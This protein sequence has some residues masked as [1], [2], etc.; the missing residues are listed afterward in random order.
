MLVVRSPG[1]QAKAIH[2]DIHI[3]KGTKATPANK[4]SFLMCVNGAETNLDYMDVSGG[5]KAH[6]PGIQHT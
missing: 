1:L 4:I 2:S 6:K 5:A 3:L